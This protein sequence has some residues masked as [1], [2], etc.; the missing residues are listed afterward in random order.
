MREITFNEIPTMLAEISNKL[1]QLLE[2]RPLDPEQSDPLMPVP[3]LQTYLEQKTGKRYARQTIYDLYCKNRI[4]GERSGK[5][6]YFRRSVIDRWLDN[7]RRMPG[8]G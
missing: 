4:P 5:Y 8:R 3:G 1:D 7:G 2:E 6:L